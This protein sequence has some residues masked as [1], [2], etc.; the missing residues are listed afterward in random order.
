M[1]QWHIIIGGET[2][3]SS[4]VGVCSVGGLGSSPPESGVG[5]ASCDA[6]PAAGVRGVGFSC[7][8][9]R[10][11]FSVVPDEARDSGCDVDS[12]GNGGGCDDDG[13]VAA[14]D[15]GCGV[16]SGGHG[17]GYDDDGPVAARDSGCGVGSG[18]NGGG[19][20]DDGP[21]EGG[22]DSLPA[23]ESGVT[24]TLESAP[25]AGWG[26]SG[27]GSG[28]HGGGCDHEVKMG[29]G[30]RGSAGCCGDVADCGIGAGGCCVGV[31]GSGASTR[32]GAGG[33]HFNFVPDEAEFAV[34]MAATG[35]AAAQKPD[36]AGCNASWTALRAAMWSRVN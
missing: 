14:R 26:G 21:D 30:G 33:W 15:S 4:S 27:V 23:T 20:D 29:G 13:A 9:G 7:G 32:E 2:A 12:G 25:A 28:G 18:V 3:V 35:R 10:W 16:G 24:L 1:G 22:S 11:Q 34:S 36:G 17:G 19:C 31:S 6:P 5:G 8:T